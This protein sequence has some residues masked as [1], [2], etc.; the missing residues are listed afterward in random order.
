VQGKVAE[1]PS[2]ELDLGFLP[3][4]I[5]RINVL[6][7]RSMC[8]LARLFFS[9]PRLSSLVSLNGSQGSHLF[10]DAAQ[11]LGSAEIPQVRSAVAARID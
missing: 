8:T 2:E 9:A 3:D 4:V 1:P 5:H 11:Q 7:L 10:A 6:L